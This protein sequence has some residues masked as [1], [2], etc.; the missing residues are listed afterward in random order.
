MNKSIGIGTHEFSINDWSNGVFYVT[1]TQE[2]GQK[3]TK[4]LV[5]I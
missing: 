3:V 5:K 2:N 4:T 1:F